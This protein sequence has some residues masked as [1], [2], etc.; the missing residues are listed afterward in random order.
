MHGEVNYVRPINLPFEYH[1]KH[2]HGIVYIYIYKYYCLTIL[3]F[4][5]SFQYKSNV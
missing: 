1:P 4:V 3:H 5:R 2:F